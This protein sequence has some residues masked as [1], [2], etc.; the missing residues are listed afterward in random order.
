MQKRGLD[1]SKK[2]Q[3]TVFIIVGLIILLVVG[4]V[5]YL[6]VTQT[7]ERLPLVAPALSELPAELRPVREYTELCINSIAVDALLLAGLHGGYINTTEWG[8]TQNILPTESK[9]VQF[10]SESNI[11][12]PY[13][14]YMKS[15]NDCAG[16]CIFDTLKPQLEKESPS[17]N[18]IESQVDKYIIS[19]L[20]ACLD[21]YAPFAG[22]GYT[23]EIIGDIVP[24][25]TVTES[26]VR[27]YLE[28]PMRVSKGDF[29]G[30][31][32]Q[33]NTF[34][35]LDIRNIYELATEIAEKQAEL[36]FIE[37]HTLNLITDFS[38]LDKNSL[39]P[40]TASTFGFNQGM[41]WSETKVKQQIEQMLTSYLSGLQ[42]FNTLN[43]RRVSAGNDIMQ[44][45]YDS[46]VLPLNINGKYNNLEVRF[47]Y[48]GWPIYFDTG[49]ELIRPEVMNI[50]FI[51]FGVQRYN[52]VYD[53][54]F[55]VLVSITDPNALNGRGYMFTFAVEAN[56]RNN[57]P[58]DADFPGY[59]G[60]YMFEKSLFCSPNHFTSGNI[61]VK[62]IDKKTN[63]PLPDV[64]VAFSA[65]ESCAIGTT[66]EN[67]TLIA[68]FPIAYNGV[69]SFMKSDYFIPAKMLTTKLDNP[70]FV[71]ADA[72]PFV[73]KEISIKK[74]VY[75][76]NFNQL[77]YNPVNLHMKEQAVLSLDKISDTVGEE[78][79][80]AVAEYWENQIQK[81]VLRLVP[82]KYE[83]SIDVFLNESF[84]LRDEICW[85]EGSF[86]DE[87]CEEIVIP[88]ETYPSGSIRIEQRSP[89]EI[90]PSDL[91]SDNRIV[92]YAIT[93]ALPTKIE[94]LDSLNNVD[95]Y[96]TRFRGNLNPTYEN[97]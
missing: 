77:A 95:A 30:E 43:Y 80:I 58:I 52:T 7:K 50:P 90:K 78:D 8:I 28:Y 17:D 2:A 33:F 92:F 1:S 37:R 74:Y 84:T 23:I 42:V 67:G 57:E 86:D 62:V 29:S 39:P 48:L 15:P 14:W 60:A 10:S 87:E 44:A 65:S 21:N 64:Q 70:D 91:Y 79:V 89:I 71:N 73:D 22:Q 32:S 88:F 51:N 9:G 36:S 56:I 69:V 31:L 34:L 19:K 24:T 5:V 54:S 81:P 6:V 20:P 68:P 49:P 55:P 85:D 61:T 25:T 93:T 75:D 4:S 46:M 26:D 76:L 94:H 41:F 47:D 11:V 40:K 53:I 72:W 16:T 97:K 66:D 27:V 35:P 13:W 83:L 82:G 63:K 3:V 12:V 18:S 96:S 59:E 45:T 38:A